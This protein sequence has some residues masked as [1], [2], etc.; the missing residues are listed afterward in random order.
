[1]DDEHWV[2]LRIIVGF[3]RIKKLGQPDAA[4]IAAALQG[5]ELMDVSADGLKIR[6]NRPFQ[7][8]MEDLVPAPGEAVQWEWQG[9]GHACESARAHTNSLPQHYSQTQRSAQGNRIH[10]S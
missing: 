6:R 4:Q 3:Q 9:N 10:L 5:S 7:C 1:M 8:Q 2:E